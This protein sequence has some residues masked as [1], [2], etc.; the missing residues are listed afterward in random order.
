M[1][2]FESF[3]EFQTKSRPLINLIVIHMDPRGFKSGILSAQLAVWGYFSETVQL[4][5]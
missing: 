2:I 5:S 3:S 1:T 4:S